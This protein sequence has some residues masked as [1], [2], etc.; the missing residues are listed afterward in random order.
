MPVIYYYLSVLM[1]LGLSSLTYSKP[2]M[3]SYINSLEVAKTSQQQQQGLMHRKYLCPKCGMIFVY[4]RDAMQSF[5]MKNTYIPLD[6][7]FVNSKGKIINIYI[8]TIPNNSQII[9]SSDEPVQ[10]IIEL[11]ANIVQ[12]LNITI[13]DYVNMGCLADKFT[14]FQQ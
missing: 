6:M 1:L 12:K 11:N 10:Y 3:C 7:I 5:W 4:P 2:N 13:G 14:K 9:Y 8:D